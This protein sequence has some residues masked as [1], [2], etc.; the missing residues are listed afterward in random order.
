ML[1]QQ[2]AAILYCYYA[3][4]SDTDFEA[5]MNGLP[6][7]KDVQNKNAYIKAE[8]D[9][10]RKRRNYKQKPQ[11]TCPVCYEDMDDGK[12]IL[13]C[14]HSFCLQCYNKFHI[15]NNTCPLC[16]DTFTDKKYQEMP[17]DF[18]QSLE[19]S[20]HQQK[21]YETHNNERV[22]LKE[23][24]HL[25]LKNM[26]YSNMKITRNQIIEMFHHY[27]SIYGSQVANFYGS[28]LFGS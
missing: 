28:Q 21:L 26:N 6:N 14:N 24:I 22:T 17:Q 27:T 10:I 23:S 15:R 2:K 16:R 5:T 3:E 11:I 9:I 8:K 19:Q 25:L 18:L 1:T 20:I 7:M 13:G 4:R 12:V